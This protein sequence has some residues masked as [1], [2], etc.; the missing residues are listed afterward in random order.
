MTTL[1]LLLALQKP[2]FGA[3]AVVLPVDAPVGAGL[4]AGA[5]LPSR[6]DGLGAQLGSGLLSPLPG[7][8]LNPTLRLPASVVPDPNGRN[9]AVSQIK[10]TMIV[11]PTGWLKRVQRKL[12]GEE[13]AEFRE[14]LGRAIATGA[15]AERIATEIIGDR[16]SVV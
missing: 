4:P 1:F 14:A 9:E 16:K 11:G 7:L 15:E 8:S 10:N 2:A 12:T 13:P 3:R 6:I 5:G